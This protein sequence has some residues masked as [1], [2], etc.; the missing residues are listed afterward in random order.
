MYQGSVDR[1][2]LVWIK[3]QI[4]QTLEGVLPACE[5]YSKN[6]RDTTPL[7]QCLEPLRCV[8]G[9]LKM[10]G[11][12]GAT[13]LSSEMVNLADALLLDNIRHKQA[14]T[15]AMATAILQLSAYLES[16]YHGQPDV[17]L[18]LLPQLNDLLAAQD[19]QLLTEGEFFS[20]DL[21][22]AVP[23]Q[24]DAE[25]LV[26]GHISEVA[27]RLR[28]G[29]L[30][31][32]LGL[33]KKHNTT[34]SLEKL[35]TVV[36]NLMHCSRSKAGK[37][38]WWLA[39]GLMDSLYDQGQE[40][41]IAVKIL[42]GRIDQQIKLL[43]VHG[44]KALVQ[45]PPDKI[46]KNL[47]YYIS[48]SKSDNQRV[49]EIKTAFGMD[50]P[51]DN[52]IQKSRESLGSFNVH[53]IETVSKQIKQELEDIKDALEVSVRATNTNTT[54][55]LAAALTSLNSVA[56]ALGMLGM[57][58]LK[59]LLHEYAVFLAPKVAAGEQLADNDLMGLAA[60]LIHVDA[61]ISDLGIDVKGT[62]KGGLPAAEYR[63]LLKLIAT[64]VIK[65]LGSLKKALLE[66]IQ[67][68]SITV[69][70]KAPDL[71]RNIRGAM[72]ILG[73]TAQANLADAIG[74]YMQDTFQDDTLPPDSHELELLADTIVGMEYFFESMLEQS[75][76]PDIAL[77]IASRS[78]R[79]LGYAPETNVWD[80]SSHKL[81]AP[82][83]LE[84]S[85]A[86]R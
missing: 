82:P 45:Q 61:S 58:N 49:L 86:H 39:S 57:S 11:I 70:H 2:T 33:I 73:Y 83:V 9:A 76:A 18:V 59:N 50:F 37:Q 40:A 1:K 51:D 4:E 6:L 5:Q 60:A 10:V 64:E 63:K 15:E 74:R 42:L 85:A 41:N 52:S 43:I 65:E 21:T 38:L 84:I 56:E 8:R 31:G 55:P 72:E 79:Q 53:L 16:L 20:P 69:M 62:R 30:S 17:P 35:I 13:L 66:F 46:C 24:P 32:L 26:N 25:C 22:I 7:E 28:P 3:T 81:T 71:L 29:Y 19:K 12:R 54:K 78:I 67:T 36:D 44:E 75:V 14:A 80:I 23:P 34:E 47:L 77:K 27:R 48:Q 68:G